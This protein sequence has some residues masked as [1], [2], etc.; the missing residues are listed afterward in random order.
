MGSVD[1]CSKFDGTQN[2][3]TMRRHDN[4]VMGNSCCLMPMEASYGNRRLELCFIVC[5]LS[6]DGVLYTYTICVLHSF[7]LSYTARACQKFQIIIHMDLPDR[8]R[9]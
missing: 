5:I 8:D 1:A 4:R 3:K 7:Y 6:E 2:S 9:L